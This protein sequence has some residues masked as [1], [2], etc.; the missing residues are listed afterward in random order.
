MK[1]VHDAERSTPG[2]SRDERLEQAVNLG[3]RGRWYC[4]AASREVRADPLHVRRLGEDLVLWRDTSG[5]VHCI[6][7]RCPHRGARLSQGRVAG[8]YIACPYH[9]IELDGL[10]VIRRVPAYADCPLEGRQGVPGYAVKEVSS[11]GAIFV[12]FPSALHP[13]PVPLDLPEELVDPAFS[14]FVYTARWNCNYRYALDNMLDPMHG[15]Y[16]HADTFTLA[17]QGESAV[18]E[19]EDRPHGFF[20]GK[21]G[22]RH[23]NFDWTEFVDN[24]AIYGRI[25]IPYPK[26]GGPGGS[27]FICGLITPIDETSMQLYSLRRR[28]IDGWQRDVWRFLYRTLFEPRH[29]IVSDQDRMVLENLVAEA[30]HRE[31]L[32]QHDLAVVRVR[33]WLLAAAQRELDA[34]DLSAEQSG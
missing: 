25:E 18:M 19:L 11:C 32:Y 34:E 27:M 28:R 22:Q 29:H 12:F 23:V 4:V 24:G 33:R 20:V 8:E 16:L 7:D 26:S 14:G 10:G 17:S 13:D 5:T 3:L 1:V 2:P 6:E 15:A 9:G 21:K 31:K 30:R